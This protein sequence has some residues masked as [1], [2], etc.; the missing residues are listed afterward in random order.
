MPT[1]GSNYIS[2]DQEDDLKKRGYSEKT[3]LT[4]IDIRRQRFIANLLIYGHETRGVAKAYKEAGFGGDPKYVDQYSARLMKESDI[5]SAL[6]AAQSAL[7][8]RFEIKQDRILK[9]LALLAFSD[10]THYKMGVNGYIEIGEEFSPAVGRAISAVEYTETETSRGDTT[11]TTKKMKIRLWDK[12]TALTNLMKY[13]GML[14][15]RSV[16]VNLDGKLPLDVAREAIDSALASRD[17]QLLPIQMASAEQRKLNERTI[18]DQGYG[19]RTTE[20]IE[21]ESPEDSA[22]NYPKNIGEQIDIEDG[23]SD[24]IKDRIKELQK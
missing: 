13:L 6:S 15:D 21:V 5:Q 16:N 23:I 18:E 8:E 14:I 19:V 9:E 2:P 10:I 3:D 4:L 7:A 24:E 22:E 17:G 12:N 1:L 20:D 11:V